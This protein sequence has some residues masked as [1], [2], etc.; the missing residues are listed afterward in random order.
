MFTNVLLPRATNEEGSLLS[1]ADWTVLPTTVKKGASIGSGS[2]ILCGITI[3]EYA[4]IGAGAVVARSVP[5]KEVWAGN[6]AR[7][8]RRLA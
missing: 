3:G 6:P 4:V 8:L 2:V 5:L 7:F 1:E